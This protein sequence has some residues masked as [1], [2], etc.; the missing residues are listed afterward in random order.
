MLI[1]C[2]KVVLFSLAGLIILTLGNTPGIAE[3][4]SPRKKMTEIERVVDFTEELRIIL[5]SG[6]EKKLAS[7]EELFELPVGTVVEVLSGKCT[8]LI[9]DKRII[10][11]TG[12]KAL[13]IRPVI[14]GENITRFT[15][16]LKI[17]YPTGE[18]IMVEEGELLPNLPPLT[19]IE[20]IDGDAW[21]STGDEE[22]TV[23]PDNTV[24]IELILLEDNLSIDFLDLPPASN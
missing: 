3:E 23:G 2:K 16:K 5:P 9:G 21:I 4:K 17:T 20:V 8:A 24:E 15:G 22:I 18:V 13:I 6:E 12:M 11:A 1:S 14:Y 19:Q 7:V 10:L